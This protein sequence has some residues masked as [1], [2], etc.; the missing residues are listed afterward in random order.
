MSSMG[1]S[2]R[3]SQPSLTRLVCVSSILAAVSIGLYLWT[4]S[5]IRPFQ[6]EYPSFV[7]LGLFT[8]PTLIFAVHSGFPV[9]LLLPSA[10][11]AAIAL[12]MRAR[13]EQRKAFVFVVFMSHWVV[14]G[15]FVAV[16][17]WAAWWAKGSEQLFR[18]LTR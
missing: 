6:P 15:F 14:L 12:R 11:V 8:P 7:T 1:S 17:L 3:L 2:Q 13:Y 16:F 18:T 9:F 10:I 5:L 4:V